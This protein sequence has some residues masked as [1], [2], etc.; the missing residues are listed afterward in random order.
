MN[1]ARLIIAAT[2]EAAM[3]PRL[4]DRIGSLVDPT[5]PSQDSGRRTS[6]RA[7]HE[8]MDAL[9]HGH[10]ES[11]K[12]DVRVLGYTFHFAPQAL[13]D[14]TLR[15]LWLLRAT[16]VALKDGVSESHDYLEFS[17]VI[18]GGMLSLVRRDAA[19]RARGMAH[20]SA[21]HRSHLGR[22]YVM[23]LPEYFY[24]D[25]SYNKGW[26]LVAAGALAVIAC[27]RRWPGAPLYFGGPGY[28]GGFLLLC[29]ITSPVW[30]WGDEGMSD[31]E[32]GAFAQVA[33]ECPGWNATTG[34]VNMKTRPL[35]PR[36][37]PSSSARLR[38]HAA[39]YTTKC[40]HWHEGYTAYCFGRLHMSSLKVVAR[41][42]LARA[43]IWQ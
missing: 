12:R 26:G 3:D 29:Q 30:L 9:P 4:S 2:V 21:S 17:R 31:W 23:V 16:H 22:S 39:R 14:S 41:S 18:R 40:P 35:H 1:S 43:G 7:D 5:L 11:T 42:L 34:I 33:S 38:R 24:F 15:E 20:F 8:G 27:L 6:R 28:P 32:Q 25:R 19:G 36:H 37:K 10:L 13:T